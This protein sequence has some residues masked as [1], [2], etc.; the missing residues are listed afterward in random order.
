VKDPKTGYYMYAQKLKGELVPSPYLAGR[1]DPAGAGL[2][3]WL[4]IP[5]ERLLALRAERLAEI[6][7]STVYAPSMG[8]IN[9]IV[10]FI[11]FS[12]DPEFTDQLAVYNDMFNASTAGTSSMYNFFQEASYGTLAVSSSFYPTPIGGKMKS[13]K[14]SS[15]RGYYK[16]Y[17][18][19]TNP[20]GYKSESESAQR[21]NALLNAAV[22]YIAPQV[23]V[24]LNTDA[25]NDG[26]VDNVCFIVSGTPTAWA[27]LLW[28]HMSWL[29]S[30]AN[31]NG[32]LVRSYN[33]QIR[34]SLMTDGASVLSHEMTHSLGAPDL[35]HY[36]SSAVEPVGNWD[37]MAA[38]SNPPQHM[39]AY[40]KYRY[41][42][43]VGS[44]PTISAP[45]RYA[46]HP[47]T[48]PAG[49]SYQIR[50]PYSP[51]EFF[52]LE[53]RKKTTIF[54]SKL[55]GEGL[56]VYRINS[57]KIGNA[58]GPPDE[59][60]I[61]RPD[62]SLQ[63][64][65]ALVKAAM[66]QGAG[67]ITIDDLSNPTCF[68]ST[69]SPGGLR[70]TD[71]SSVG[72]SI[73]FT[74]KW[75]LAAVVNSVVATAYGSDSVLVQWTATSQC[76][77]KGFEVQRAAEDSESAFQPLAGSFT[78]G[79]G[80]L[81]DSR[82]FSFVDR[83]NVGERFYRLKI[84]DTSNAVTYTHSSVLRNASGITE[85]TSPATYRLYQNYPNPFNPKTGVRFQVVGVSDVKIVVFDLLGREVAIL[86]NERRQPGT[87][88][89]TFDG[90][91]M[92][93]GI[94]FYR[95][96]AGSFVETRKMLLVK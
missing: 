16:P 6:A 65:G 85:V 34:S 44:I 57:T 2:Q 70:I 33:L 29:N 50:S 55:P 10:V 53:F 59:V 46:L 9:N 24:S 90:S 45:G 5:S 38:N 30:S 56:L 91:S 3:P 63:V 4:N 31:I 22:T 52:V 41:L 95:L 76:R 61:Y 11:R 43:W 20:V 1:D 58:E 87:Y 32:E 83:S 51:T 21:E 80:T 62:G 23:P 71:V 69:G 81:A 36:V 18:A 96:Q 47:L 74:V 73:S 54:E 77:C 78:G 86:V 27:T 79:D 68:L 88:E 17:D 89:V 75:P 12:D 35:Y 94:Y 8:A 60:Y 14:D 72:D 82:T 84:T 92:A 66:S 64:N 26:Y 39:G 7:G 19:A 25:N 67:F 37:L 28:P 49:N 40:M 13:Y 93:S 15:P 42:G 48:S